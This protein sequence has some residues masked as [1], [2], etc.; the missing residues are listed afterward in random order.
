M[1]AAHQ[2][3][4]R[5]IEG[6]RIKLSLVIAIWIERH[7]FVGMTGMAKRMRDGTVYGCSAPA[8]FQAMK[9]FSTKS[10]RRRSDMPQA[11]AKRRLVTTMSVSIFASSRS[12]PILDLAQAVIGLGGS[13]SFRGGP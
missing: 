6:R 13:V 2:A 8:L 5:K 4:H 10:N 12:V 1:N 11:V 9:S 3:A 7:D